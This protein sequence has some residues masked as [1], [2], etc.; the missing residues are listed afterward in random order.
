MEKSFSERVFGMI[1]LVDKP[2]G[3]TSHSVVA[4][5]KY[6]LKNYEKDPKVG[7]SGTLDP[8]CT[9]LLPVFTGKDTKLISILP[10]GKRYR[11]GL[12][13]GIETDTEDATGIT[14]CERE[15]TVS[16]EEVFAAAKSFVGKYMQTPPM[17][18]AIKKN[19]TKLYELARRGVEVER[20]AREITIYS[21]DIF[22][23]EKKN[24]YFLDVSCSAGTYIR[25][26]CSDIG[27]KL[28]CGA[29]MS[30]LRRTFSNGFS[31]ENAKSLDETVEK[32]NSGFS[33]EISFSA[34]DVFDVAKTVVPDDGLK[35]Y[36]NG[37]EISLKRTD[38]PFADGLL[39]VYSRD[40]K[41]CGIGKTEN[42]CVKAVVNYID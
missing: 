27:K 14:L 32:I 10:H 13:L 36:L 9:G 37:G 17:Y 16:A 23:S 2:A 18:S 29:C 33:S 41:F 25:T 31:V 42:G 24:E 20:E 38:T 4:K 15:V 26:L 8:M 19:G 1:F 5:I 3:M 11:A 35:Y 40:G 39:R 28:G 7:H 12:L 21:I 30:S 6:A 34:E 22:P